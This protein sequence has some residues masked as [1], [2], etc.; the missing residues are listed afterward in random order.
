MLY[1]YLSNKL[2]L[3]Y[4]L[5]SIEMNSFFEKCVYGCEKL[6]ISVLSV[7]QKN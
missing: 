4:I 1:F 7:K 6:T 3:L 5:F 2:E